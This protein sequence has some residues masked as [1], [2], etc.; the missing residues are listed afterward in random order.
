VAVAN[1]DKDKGYK[2]ALDLGVLKASKVSGQVLTSAKLDAHNT[3]GEKE[4]IAPAPYRGG[5]ISG[6]KLLLDVPAKA[7]V[8]VGLE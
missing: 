4:E 3:P 2:L 1:A 7:V 8:V 5:K 6:G